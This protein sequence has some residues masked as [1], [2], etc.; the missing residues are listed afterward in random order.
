MLTPIIREDLLYYLWKTKSFNLS[1][2]LT[3]DG[4][5]IEII[6]FGNQNYDSGPDFSNG[7]V[8]IGETIWA[9]NIEMHVY[10]SDWE[11][12]NHDLDK[13]YDNVILH[14][15]Y[16]H[17]REVH[18][19]TEQFIPCLELKN[20]IPKK[21]KQN[22]SQLISNN[23][24]IPCENQ[25][26]NVPNHTV[27][28]WLQRMVAERLESKTEYLKSILE[29]TNND[30]EE[31]MY[32]FLM[33]Y[34]GA[35][36]NMD[37]FESL[38]KNL[39]LSIIQKNKDVLQT[40]EALLFGQAGMLLATHTSDNYYESLKS[41]YLFLSKKYQLTNIPPVS[42]KFAR[43]RPA[44]F[45]TIRIAQMAQII[46]NTE[47]LFSQILDAKEIKSIRH[48]FH[49][50]PSEYWEDHYRFGTDSIYKEKHLGDGFI[51][52]IIIN[53]VS[54][55]LFLYGKSIADEQYCERAIKHLES[56]KPEQNKIITNYKALGIKTSSAADSQGLLQL[57]KAYCDPKLCLSCS[58]GNKLIG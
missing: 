52:L 30:W 54:P 44:G 2:L 9:G 43:M 7:K 45:P 23:N 26:P 8:K 42:W 27:T 38:A 28:F 16:E 57:K 41:E 39:P 5:P 10:S 56:L 11:R 24:W 18:T 15:V 22:Y 20:R 25:L 33:R 13:A 35:R 51:D 3:E 17:D 6:D 53:V 37:P 48:L 46:C 4:Q 49:A 50:I 21:L 36:V 12:H 19:T 58:I 47:H 1:D 55:I 40:I 31:T 14:V 34:M 32:V 29:Y